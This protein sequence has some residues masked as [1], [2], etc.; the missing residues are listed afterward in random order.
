MVFLTGALVLASE[1]SVLHMPVADTTGAHIRKLLP[2]WVLL[3]L[4]DFPKQSG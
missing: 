4:D 2:L 3:Q 1:G